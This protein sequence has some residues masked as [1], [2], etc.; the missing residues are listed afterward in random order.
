MQIISIQSVSIAFGGPLLL[1]N[2]S[3]EVSRGERI[4]FLGRNGEGKSTLL[5]IIAGVTIPDSGNVIST[6]GIKVAYLPQEVPENLDGTVYDIVAR[7]AGE[8]GN[9]L[10][11]LRYM[12]QHG[13]DDIKQ[14]NL[15]L[16]INDADAWQLQVSIDK[17]LSQCGL[18]GDLKF[19]MLSGG[20]RRRVFLARA[21]IIQPDI[22]LLDEPTNHLDIETIEWLEKFLIES[23]LTVLFVTHDRKLLKRLATR[24]I[25]LDRG[26]LVDWSC[27]YETF[28]E[29][30]NAILAA[31]E[32]AWD[33]F[34][35]KL[36][37]EEIWLRKGVKA[38]RTR[39]EGRVR[40]LLKMRSERSKRRE[41]SGSVAMEISKAERSGDKVIDVKKISYS[42]EN[43]SIIE[44]FS[45][46][47]TRGDRIGIIGPNGCGKT[48]L[49][50]L[51]LGRI[52][53]RCGEIEIGTN[54]QVAYFDQLRQ[55]LDLQKSVWENVAPDGRDTVFINGNPKHV[56]SYLHDFLFTSE[57]AASPVKQLSG[58]ERNRLLL[59]KLFIIPSN[60]LVFDEP[61]NDLDTE[62]LEL[63]EE[64]LGTYNGTVVLVSHD[65]E[66]LDNIVTS[67]LVFEGN[68]L[69]K[70]YVGGYSDWQRI[71][72]M[73]APQQL[74]KKINV[75][76]KENKS[77]DSGKQKRTYR[78]QKEFESLTSEIEQMENEL[79]DVTASMANP[80]SY[81]SNDFAIEISR[82]AAELEKK[83]S[84]AYQ[85][86]EELLQK[87][88]K[89]I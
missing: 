36:S 75:P 80:D 78:E 73:A 26:K 21:L 13:K 56:F 72:E 55:T 47:I 82:K 89:V 19:S 27:P 31:E 22:L 62:T 15:H 84:C 4:C 64:L 41:R 88:E 8:V 23:K 61:T 49:I 37:Q 50:N 17:V 68:G 33:E 30:K 83:L 14:A 54:V 18:D 85:R 44:N 76:V 6:P 48:T 34:D 20:V 25:E 67:T 11:E 32:K 51:M 28:V 7:G 53:P 43:K 29:R 40:A 87:E 42:Y 38:R 16:A 70:E 59:A 81:K 63:L 46:T 3:F 12:Q 77:S 2:I 57:R 45:T 58:G 66:F 9:L 60:V 10:S 24:I 35:K 71:R 39:N 52:K 65:R 1:E 86:W 69:V 79:S 74:A 5:K